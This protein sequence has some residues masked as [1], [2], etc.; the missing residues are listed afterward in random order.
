MSE[1]KARFSIEQYNIFGYLLPG[2]MF[3]C[4][5]ILHSKTLINFTLNLFSYNMEKNFWVFASIFYLII[6]Y[7]MGHILASISSLIIENIFVR[8]LLGYPTEHLIPYEQFNKHKSKMLQA[9][10]LGKRQLLSSQ[11]KSTHYIKKIARIVP[12]LI[13][14]DYFQPYDSNFSNH[15]LTKFHS[16]FRFSPNQKELYWLAFSKVAQHHPQ[17]YRR[18][19]NFVG[20]YG[21]ARNSIVALIYAAFNPP[22]HYFFQSGMIPSGWKP[23]LIVL[24]IVMFLNYLHLLK[25]HNSEVYISFAAI[26]D[27]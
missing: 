14:H 12:K 22:Q 15:L 19:M 27:E 18:S 25:R 16:I 2:M 20:L 3:L 21:F 13:M 26:S 9:T 1:E 4:F 5:F 11:K 10:R 24:S 7:I 8:G 17:G 23:T 6:A